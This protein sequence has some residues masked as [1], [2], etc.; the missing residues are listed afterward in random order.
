MRRSLHSHDQQSVCHLLSA[1]HCNL[2]CDR[3]RSKYNAII[4]T[5]HDLLISTA[6]N[7]V[8]VFERVTN[9]ILV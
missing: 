6:V 4:N 9:I 7:V 2:S 1:H 5:F 8:K 3:N